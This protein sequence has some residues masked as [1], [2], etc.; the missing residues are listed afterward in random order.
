MIIATPKSSDNNIQ[1]EILV[2][3]TSKSVSSDESNTE[4]RNETYIKKLAERT[5][6]DML[7][8]I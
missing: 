6:V 1:S 2:S 7:E 8:S 4:T 5:I 3:E